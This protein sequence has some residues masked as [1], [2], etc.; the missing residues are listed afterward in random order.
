MGTNLLTAVGEKNS[1]IAQTNT[2][3]GSDYHL[4]P[5]TLFLLPAVPGLSHISIIN[6]ELNRRKCNSISVA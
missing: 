6:T 3:K 1:E 4:I 5:S 2:K